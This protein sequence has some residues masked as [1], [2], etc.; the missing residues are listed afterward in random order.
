MLSHVR[1]VVSVATFLVA[2][3]NEMHLFNFVS[4]G[5]DFLLQ[6]NSTQEMFYSKHKKA[7]GPSMGVCLVLNVGKGWTNCPSVCFSRKTVWNGHRGDV[8]WQHQPTA[9]TS[10]QGFVWF[11]GKENGNQHFVQKMILSWECS[12]EHKT[13]CSHFG[14]LDWCCVSFAPPT[15]RAK[16][17]WKMLIAPKDWGHCNASKVRY[18]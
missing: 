1:P 15:T 10:F 7:P 16:K 13:T 3:E 6:L 11:N 14:W 18:I 17:P 2:V 9:T 5:I 12:R 4:W 8:L